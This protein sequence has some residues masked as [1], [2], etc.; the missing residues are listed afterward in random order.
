VL[1]CEARIATGRAGRYLAQLCGHAGQMSRM[2]H[3]PFRHGGDAAMPPQ[4]RHAEYADDRGVIDFGSGR[5]ELLATPEALMLRVG[6]EDAEH[7]ARLKE[8][9][10][11]R[12]E[13]IGR[14]DGLTVIWNE[15]RDD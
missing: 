8:G 15:A 1:S 2:K 10:A 4:V 5:C 7:L 12:V 6:A 11:A 3:L 9:M 13:K 14:R